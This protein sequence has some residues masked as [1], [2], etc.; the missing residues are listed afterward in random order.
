MQKKLL[1]K[2]EELTLHLI[3]QNKQIASMQEEINMLK[4]ENEGLDSI[5]DYLNKHPV[6]AFTL[7]R[8]EKGLKFRP[9][10]RKGS[11]AKKTEYIHKMTT[12]KIH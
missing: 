10:R 12:E 3:D 1:E 2:V 11:I 7:A 8:L 6:N 9:K 4:S 5:Q